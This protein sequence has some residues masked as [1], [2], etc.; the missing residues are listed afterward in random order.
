MLGWLVRLAAAVQPE[1]ESFSLPQKVNPSHD[2]LP[3][4][5]EVC[6][7]LRNIFPRPA[8]DKTANA[9]DQKEREKRE[10]NVLLYGNPTDKRKAVVSKMSSNIAMVYAGIVRALIDP[11]LPM[12]AAADDADGGDE[13]GFMGGANIMTHRYQP[14]LDAIE[15]LVTVLEFFEEMPM[16]Y[17]KQVE[18]P[19]LL[20]R[21]GAV[22]KVVKM[23]GQVGFMEVTML[24]PRL[25]RDVHVIWCCLTGQ[26]LPGERDVVPDAVLEYLSSVRNT[27]LHI[28]ST[29]KQKQGQGSAG[30]TERAHAPDLGC[31]KQAFRLE[32][33]AV[34]DAI[35]MQQR[36]LLEAATGGPAAGGGSARTGPVVRSEEILHAVR[37]SFEHEYGQ[38]SSFQSN[39]A[40]FADSDFKR[41]RKTKMN[42]AG[43][44]VHELLQR[45]TPHMQEDS[46][47]ALLSIVVVE[48]KVICPR[49]ASQC[50]RPS[51]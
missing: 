10:R 33:H 1:F 6:E 12:A 27:P 22:Q 25:R 44:A 34:E 19:Y 16:S 36:F 49:S 24:S 2:L 48:A 14:E 3:A 26:E 28:C 29:K 15:I 50:C 18:L 51:P 23:I 11:A 32:T 46:V 42:V 5:L 17:R 30:G 41:Q 40:G 20:L 9:D 45:A 31:R 43:F 35:G 39:S 21:L 7:A 13:F 4:T 38:S 8:D 37:D 47:R